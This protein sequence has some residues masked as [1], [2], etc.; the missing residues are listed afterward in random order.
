[1]E[2]HINFSE[3]SLEA[4]PGSAGLRTQLPGMAATIGNLASATGGIGS[5]G[6]IT[7]DQ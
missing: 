5:K 7:R 4:T 1:M 3:G 2:E 6:I